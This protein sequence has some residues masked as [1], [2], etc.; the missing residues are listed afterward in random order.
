MIVPILTE[1]ERLLGLLR[2]IDYPV[3]RVIVID[4]GDMID[5]HIAWHEQLGV[6]VHV[7]R[8]PHNLGVAASWNLGIKCAPLSPYFLIVNHD[9]EFG[10]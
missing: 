1:P 9:I 8:L 2:S 3:G 6:K 10:P 4:N 7:V 5:P